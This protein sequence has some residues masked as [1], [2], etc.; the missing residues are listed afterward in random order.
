MISNKF[1]K[2]IT[3]NPW[4]GLYKSEES[5]AIKLADE[6]MH[7]IVEKHFFD[8]YTNNKNLHEHLKSCSDIEKTEIM[9]IVSVLGYFKQI[10]RQKLKEQ[11]QLCETII[12]SEMCE[13]N[14]KLKYEAIIEAEKLKHALDTDFV[15]LVV[16]SLYTKI[17]NSDPK[18][19]DRKIA[20]RIS[21]ILARLEI[22][23]DTKF[24]TL[25]EAND[26]ADNNPELI[27][28]GETK[29][30]DRVKK[31]FQ[32]ESFKEKNKPVHITDYTV[33]KQS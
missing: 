15:K 11:L 29:I 12:A 23:C 21:E 9:K 18:S 26:F 6:K 17:K 7:E 24:L 32:K 4:K 19:S 1:L 3:L 13:R 14:L 2:A 8:T 10:D 30:Y 28:T 5:D 25:N 16:N 22:Y 33:S 27:A 31:L 20:I